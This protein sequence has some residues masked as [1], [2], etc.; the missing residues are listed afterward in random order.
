MKNISL[1]WLQG[2]FETV[3][4]CMVSVGGHSLLS[5]VTAS[6]P[7]TAGI[8]GADPGGGVGVGGRGGVRPPSPPR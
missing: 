2:I 1:N 4:K 3:P 8:S 5:H 6:G 7:Y